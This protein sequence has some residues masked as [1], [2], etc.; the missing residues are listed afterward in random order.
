MAGIVPDAD[1]QR[2]GE[3][4]GCVPDTQGASQCRLTQSGA[5]VTSGYRT[6]QYTSSCI[7][8]SLFFILLSLRF[9][10]YHLDP[11]FKVRIK[12][13]NGAAHEKFCITIEISQ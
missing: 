5:R 10:V 12:M 1:T 6:E 2:G 13:E 7:A 9:S 11:G 3:K 4:T 8:I